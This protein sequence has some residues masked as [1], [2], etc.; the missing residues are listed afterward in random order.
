MLTSVR[1]KQ[2]RHK[3]VTFGC[4]SVASVGADNVLRI[5]FKRVNASIRLLDCPGF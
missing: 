4:Q 5:G 2:T 1:L 3:V